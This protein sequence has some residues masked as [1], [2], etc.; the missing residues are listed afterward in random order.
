[1]NLKLLANC[2]RRRSPR[3]RLEL[4]FFQ[5]R[6]LVM[7]NFC[8]G[9]RFQKSHDE[10][11]D[12]S[13]LSTVPCPED[14]VIHKTKFLPA[15]EFRYRR[16][17]YLRCSLWYQRRHAFVPKPSSAYEHLSLRVCWLP[18][19]KCRMAGCRQEQKPQDLCHAALGPLSRETG[20][21]I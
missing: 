19:K 8:G 11:H 14:M 3:V 16:R 2:P 20:R 7:R 1:M 13:V 10:A 9:G 12:P 4:F 15:V 6:K 17:W 21:R 18:H 5:K